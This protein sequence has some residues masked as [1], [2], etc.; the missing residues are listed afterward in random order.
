MVTK[1]NDIQIQLTEEKVRISAELERFQVSNRPQDERREGSPFG[2]REEEATESLELERRLALQRQLIDQLAEVN[3][4][5][6][7]FVKGTYG[8]CESCGQ[9]IEEA[10]LRAVPKAPLCFIVECVFLFRLFD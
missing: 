3:I 10:R 1:Y 7:K 2:K 8:V 4:A 5:L 6:E 9:S